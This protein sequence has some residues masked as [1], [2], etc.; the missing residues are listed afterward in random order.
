MPKIKDSTYISPAGEG[1]IEHLQQ[2]LRNVY[3]RMNEP[4]I[5]SN[6]LGKLDIESKNI[7]KKL[8]ELQKI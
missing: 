4:G 6:E 7:R 1:T 3:N 5:E 2:E 8:F